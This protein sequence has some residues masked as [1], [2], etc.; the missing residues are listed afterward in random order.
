MSSIKIAYKTS[1]GKFDLDVEF[2]IPGKGISVLFGPSGS[3]KSSVL[4]HLAGLDDQS[5]TQYSKL[6]L[7]DVVYDDLENN[8]KLNPWQRKIAY[9]FQDNRLFPN[10]TV[11]RNIYFGHKRRQSTLDVNEVVEKF[12]IKDLLDRYPDQLSGGQK[13][14]VSMVRALLSNP[15]LLIMDEPLAALDYQ[16]RE[17]LLPYIECIHKELTIPIIYVSHDIKEVL[18]LADY[19][20]VMNQGKVID[21]G[22]LA[23]LCINQPLLTQAEGASFILQGEVEKIFS[24]EMLL[25]INCENQSIY[26]TGKDADPGDALR[27]LIHAKD[28][29]L[30]LS[31][32]G[33]SSILNCIPVVVDSIKDKSNGK[34]EVI[35]KLGEQ[36]IVSMISYRSAKALG[37]EKGKSIFAQF[38]ATAMIK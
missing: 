2:E 4:N 36:L 13:Q 24:E 17:E 20:V 11:Q 8:I 19:I 9:V 32:A 25:Q 15:E 35:A 34:Y 27:I 30:C 21:K 3:G 18:R 5:K 10:M 31:P 7:N 38:K 1:L 29:S 12:K 16:S 22:E 37:L 26:I 33:D 23:E 28:V 14:R 6:E